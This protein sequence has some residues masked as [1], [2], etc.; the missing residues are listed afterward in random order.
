MADVSYYLS[1][2]YATVLRRDEDGDVVATIAE[3]DGC[4]AHGSDH[5]EAL[6]NLRDAQA[7]WVEAAIEAAQD[8]P[9][10]EKAEALPSGK[11]VVR[12]P[13]Y[14]H[15]KLNRLAKKDGVSLNQIVLM[16]ATEHVSRREVYA[17]ADAPSHASAWRHPEKANWG[18][19]GRAQGL[20][21]LGV[22]AERNAL[23]P[24]TSM[25]EYLSLQRRR[26]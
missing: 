25:N 8:I 10:P 20:D 18:Q 4:V 15:Q 16:A 7:A 21:F 22:V 2:P 3:L 26:G 13:R 6:A 1:L 17:E 12:L 24:V 9:L 11:F 14:L 19:P 23:A 5:A